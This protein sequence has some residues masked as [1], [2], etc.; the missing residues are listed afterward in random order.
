MDQDEDIPMS[1]LN[2]QAQVNIN[3][4][5]DSHEDVD[6]LV[7]LED[8]DGPLREWLDE[9]RVRREIKN[10]FKSF[11]TSYSDTSGETVYPE[12]LNTMCLD[13]GCSLKV[14]YMH[15]SEF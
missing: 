1:L 14:S 13:N 4:M 8:F 5:I 11:L 2:Q 15:L 10:R 3:R 9:D 6:N 7:N 12:R